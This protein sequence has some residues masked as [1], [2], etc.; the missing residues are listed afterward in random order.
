MMLEVLLW[1]NACISGQ[2]LDVERGAIPLGFRLACQV[3]SALRASINVNWL[4]RWVHWMHLV[5]RKVLLS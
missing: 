1:L 2:N 4:V 3:V 5:D